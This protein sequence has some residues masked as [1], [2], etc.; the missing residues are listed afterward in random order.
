MHP[1]IKG[2]LSAISAD[3]GLHNV[4]P[5]FLVSGFCCSIC[6]VQC[7]TTSAVCR[8]IRF[9][10]SWEFSEFWQVNFFTV[11]TICCLLARV[12][13]GCAPPVHVTSSQVCHSWR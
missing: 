11:S 4:L 6:I 5:L 8:H 12:W 7:V 9:T 13:P 3:C 10:E 1:S 2:C